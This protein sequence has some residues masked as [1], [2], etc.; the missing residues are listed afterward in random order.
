M[1][2]KAAPFELLGEVVWSQGEGDEPG[3]GIRFIYTNDSQ[4]QEFEAVVELLMADSLGS[5]L[6]DRLLNKPVKE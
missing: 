2:Q 5:A 4:R 3:M 1:P 6:T